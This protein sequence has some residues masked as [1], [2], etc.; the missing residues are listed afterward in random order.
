MDIE[1][2]TISEMISFEEMVTEI[3]KLSSLYN[4]THIKTSLVER[5]KVF[6]SCFLQDIKEV[7]GLCKL[8]EDNTSTDTDLIL[9]FD[10]IKSLERYLADN[11]SKLDLPLKTIQAGYVFKNNC[12]YYQITLSI[13]LSIGE[14]Y[15]INYDSDLIIKSEFEEITNKITK[16]FNLIFTTNKSKLVY[17]TYTGD[18]KESY[19]ISC[20]NAEMTIQQLKEILKKGNDNEK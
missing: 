1:D 7:F 12:M 13:I 11:R 4:Y 9:R 14:R 6:E 20:A 2:L 17:L 16:K 3:K 15:T 18:I 19:V 8:K 10:N 5:K